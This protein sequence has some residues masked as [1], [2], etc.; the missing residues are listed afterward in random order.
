MFEHCIIP[1]HEANAVAFASNHPDCDTASFLDAVKAELIAGIV[2]P[3]NGRN[4]SHAVF[5]L[6]R[7]TP[8]VLANRFNLPPHWHVSIKRIIRTKDEA[9]LR[10]LRP[11]LFRIAIDRFK[12]IIIHKE[13][14]ALIC[15]Q[16]IV[17]S[18]VRTSNQLDFS[19]GES[20]L[21]DQ[22]EVPLSMVNFGNSQKLR[23]LPHL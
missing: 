16:G 22:W 12:A 8:S 18:C 15:V 2:A 6:P 14:Y 11:A 23:T 4:N 20:S 3:T 5:L 17:H 7:T 1:S 10:K 9:V 19:I 13:M 21:V